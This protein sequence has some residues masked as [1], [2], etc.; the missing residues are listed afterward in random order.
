MSKTKNKIR[1]SFIGTN[2]EDVTGSMTLIEFGERKIL[3]ETGL[4]Q[5]ENLLKNYQINTRKLPFK[6]S[7]ID[8][9]F[10]GHAHIDHI[11]ILARLYAQGCHAKIIV[12]KGIPMLFELMAQDSAFIFEKDIET[13]KRR[14]GKDVFP[15]YTEEDISATLPYF[16]EFDYHG[17]IDLDNDIS[18]RFIPSG[19]IICAAQI[20]LWIKYNNHISKIGYTSDIGNLVIPK[21][22]VKPFEPIEKCNVLIAESTY[23]DNKRSVTMK[24]REKDLEKIQAV[25]DTVC[26]DNRHKVLIPVFALDRIQNILTILYKMFGK[27][28]SFNIPILIDSPLA[29]KITRLYEQLLDGEDLDTYREVMN[30]KN[31]KFVEEYADSK[32]Y[33]ESKD[34]MIICACSGFMSAGRSRQWAKLLLPDS[35]SHILFVGYSSEGSLS[36]KIKK[37]KV[38]KTISIDGKAYPNRCNVTSLLSFSSHMQHDELLKYYSDVNSDKIAL[39]HGDFK[40]KCEF[41]KEL[42]EEISKKN[43]SGRVIC[44]NKST[45]ILI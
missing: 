45:E 30:W 1:V 2:A 7:E 26:C 13:I 27:D 37:G 16:Q 25:I 14:Y 29:C 17:K 28:E 4:Y 34:P 40:P 10:I 42:Q 38:T 36:Y 35:M 32:F 44:V 43:K 41:T 12:P 15:I 6:P 19:H 24:D 9:I 3:I 23:A 22:Y 20:E 31:I 8:L 39:V 21:Y 18:F 11:G 33:Q 5:S